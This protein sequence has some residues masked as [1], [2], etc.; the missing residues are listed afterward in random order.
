MAAGSMEHLEDRMLL[1][2]RTKDP[3]PDPDLEKPLAW[4]KVAKIYHFEHDPSGAL[5]YKRRLDGA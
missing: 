4:K 2:H 1:R 3:S 5:R